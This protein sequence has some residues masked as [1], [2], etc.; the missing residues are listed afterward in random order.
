MACAEINFPDLVKKV[1]PDVSVPEKRICPDQYVGIVKD[2]NNEQNRTAK[3]F[4]GRKLADSR[5]TGEPCLILIL[6]SPHI[7]E[8]EDGLGPAKGPTGARIRSHILDEALG[9]RGY[10]DYGLILVN[11]IQYQCSLGDS[12]RKHRD[13]IFR[14]VWE[15]G[16]KECFIERIKKY[17]HDGDVIAICCTKGKDRCDVSNELRVLVH[18]AIK[19]EEVLVKVGKVLRKTHPASWWSSRNRGAELI[20]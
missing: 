15:N 9:F 20:Y 19:E 2:L 6:E 12:T 18:K 8:F 7:N 4:L 3:D 13:R 17:F 16:G 10:S 11:A 1:K 5:P 14:C